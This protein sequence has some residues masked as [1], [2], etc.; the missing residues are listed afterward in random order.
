MFTR[1]FLAVIL[2]ALGAQWASAGVLVRAEQVPAVV[3]EMTA[4]VPGEVPIAPPA[5]D[6]AD[7]SLDVSLTS[8]SVIA[9]GFALSVWSNDLTAD[10]PL[11]EVIRVWSSKLPTC[12]FLEAKLKPA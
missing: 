6:Q 8:T 1:L 2:T 10:A 12:P 3:N 4:P 7:F 11:R 9:G 5:F